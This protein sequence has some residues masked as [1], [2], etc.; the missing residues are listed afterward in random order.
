MGDCGAAHLSR[1]ELEADFLAG[2]QIATHFLLEL[3]LS[4]A[5]A[6]VLLVN[7]VSALAT[8]QHLTA[9]S[10]CLLLALLHGRCMTKPFATVLQLNGDRFSAAFST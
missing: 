6:E 4:V 1:V 3:L 7:L 9:T 2:D 8:L 5:R 10:H